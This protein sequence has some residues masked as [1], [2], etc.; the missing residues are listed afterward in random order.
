M[1]RSRGRG[2]RLA[3]TAAGR[4]RDAIDGFRRSDPL[5][6]GPTAPY[7]DRGFAY[8]QAGNFERAARISTAYC[9]WMVQHLRALTLRGA[10]FAKFGRFQGDRRFHRGDPAESEE[11]GSL[12]FTRLGA[13]GDGEHNKALEDRDEAVKLRPDA[14]AYIAVAGPIMSSDA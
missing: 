4:Y 11:R 12:S 7:M 14:L 9:A 8:G 3:L 2:R 6:T 5:E 10:A 1:I 13:C